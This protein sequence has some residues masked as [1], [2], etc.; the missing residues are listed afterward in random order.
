MNI[1]DTNGPKMPRVDVDFG[2]RANV[3]I[4]LEDFPRMIKKK[5]LRFFNDEGEFVS[6]HVSIEDYRRI[7]D[8]Y[9]LDT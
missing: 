3:S 6:I 7:C 2:T 1:D 4:K 5:H 8:L 9:G